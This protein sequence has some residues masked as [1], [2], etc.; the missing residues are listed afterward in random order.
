ME[1]SLRAILEP[2][3]RYSGENAWVT[4]V[5][6]VMVLTMTAGYVERIV[7]RQFKRG[8]AKTGNPWDDA[9]LDAAHRPVTVLIW[10]IGLLFAA[11]IISAWTEAALFQAVGPIRELAVIALLVWFV[12]RLINNI[13]SRVLDPKV[14]TGEALDE[15]TWGAISKILRASVY[16]TAAL[17]ALQTLGYSISGVLAF[18]GVGG[19]AVGF[20]AKDLLANFFGG[21]IIYLDKPFRVGDWIRSP[22]REI[23]GTVE[24]IGWRLSVVRT[25]DKRPLYIPNAIFSNIAIENPSRM[26]NRRIFETIGVRYDDVEALPDIVRDVEQMLRS[27]PDIDTAGTLMVNFNAFADSSLDFLIYTFTR[28][29]VWTEYHAVKQDVLFRISQIIAGYGAEVA[30]PTS[31]LHVAELPEQAPPGGAMEPETRTDGSRT[32]PPAAQEA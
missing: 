29:T 17:V 7:F 1:V 19:I 27:H 5:F 3:A 13:E 28:T 12:V 11:D 26:T 30:F 32:A 20:A 4:Q 14:D 15:T 22:D 2:I 16:I 21:L 25:F 9:L 24:R 18:G 31:T 10:A 6:I 23:E 8:A